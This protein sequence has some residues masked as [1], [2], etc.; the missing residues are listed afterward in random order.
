MGSDYRLV[1]FASRI[2]ATRLVRAASA[3]LVDSTVD[4]YDGSI[5]YYLLASPTEQRIAGLCHEPACGMSAASSGPTVVFPTDPYAMSS[6]ASDPAAV[7][8]PTPQLFSYDTLLSTVDGCYPIVATVD[9]TTFNG[10]SAFCSRSDDEVGYI[11][12][13]N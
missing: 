10:A 12:V 13:V 3:T 1:D 6:C 2:D 7:V 9:Y 4:Y 5:G 8:N 11:Y